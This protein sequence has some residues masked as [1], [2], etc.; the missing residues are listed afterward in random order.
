MKTS[1][2]NRTGIAS[3]AAYFETG[4]I[5]TIDLTQLIP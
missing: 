4:L 2:D 3:I 1:I 5:M